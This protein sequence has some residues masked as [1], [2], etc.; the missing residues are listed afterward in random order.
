MAAQRTA[1]AAFY[2]VPSKKPFGF[3]ADIQMPKRSF[4]SGKMF[5]NPQTTHLQPSQG[6]HRVTTAQKSRWI[7]SAHLFPN[8]TK[9]LRRTSPV[10]SGHWHCYY[11]P[12]GKTRQ[13]ACIFIY[14][15][16]RL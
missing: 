5:E 11:G 16:F 6:V 8:N 3:D 4:E 13:V 2:R 12:N 7:V 1:N 14:F 15:E 9:K 10:Y